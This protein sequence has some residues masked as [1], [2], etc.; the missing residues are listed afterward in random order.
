MEK[1]KLFIVIGMLVILVMI[2]IKCGT[3]NSIAGEYRGQD[4]DG[5]LTISGNKTWSYQQEDYWGS[6]E[7]DWNGT[8]S[9]GDDGKYVL[10]C[11]DAILYLEVISDDVV[12]LTSNKDSWSAEDF[13]R[14]K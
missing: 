12:T 1:K 14:V 13:T 5:I 4:G 11:D 8:Y 9:K 6:G 2:L 10:E 7:I 3:S